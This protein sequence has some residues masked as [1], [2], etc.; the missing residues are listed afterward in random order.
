MT[1]KR[2]AYVVLGMHRSNTSLVAGC[3]H[4]AGVDF[5]R[6][7]IPANENNPTG[8]WELEALN[9]IHD[10]ILREH[11]LAW[12]SPG[13]LP[14]GWLESTVVTRARRDMIELLEGEFES[15]DIF[16]IK[17]PR[18]CRFVPLWR[19]IFE[20]KEIAVRWLFVVRHPDA[21]A[22]S[23][24]RRGDMP[25]ARA[26]SLWASYNVNV[27]A[28][29]S[30]EDDGFVLR[31]E[32]FV[33]DP[34]AFT[35]RALGGKWP[36]T[37]EGDRIEEKICSFCRPDLQHFKPK[38]KTAEF[39]DSPFVRLYNELS[40]EWG[41]VGES[42]RTLR[43]ALQSL[44]SEYREMVSERKRLASR[45][46]VFD[47]GRPPAI[48]RFYPM[49]AKGMF[50]EWDAR[51]AALAPLTWTE[52][53]FECDSSDLKGR[54]FFRIDPA[55]AC[56]EVRLRD[57]VWACAEGSVLPVS[58]DAMRTEGPNRVF[59]RFGGGVDLFL[60]GEEVHLLI[61]PPEGIPSGRVILRGRIRFEPRLPGIEGVFRDL[62][63]EKVRA[64]EEIARKQREC[65]VRMEE[66]RSLV[67]RVELPSEAAGIPMRGRREF[68]ASQ[69][70]NAWYQ[71]RI[72]GDA[73]RGFWAKY[74]SARKRER[75]KS[76]RTFVDA[77][78]FPLSSGDIRSLLEEM[79]SGGWLELAEYL[80]RYPD[81][82]ASGA[83]PI[84]HYFLHGWREGRWISRKFDPAFYLASNPDVRASRQEPL[85]HFFLH[86]KAEGRSPAPGL[87]VGDAFDPG[88]SSG[89]DRTCV[90]FFSGEPHTPGHVYRI[91]RLM[92]LLPA[93]EFETRQFKPGEEGLLTDLLERAEWLWIWRAPISESLQQVIDKARGLGVQ[94][95]YDLDDLMIRPELADPKVIDGIRSMRLKVEETVDLYSRTQ[96]AFL[97][98]DQ[99][100]APTA[101]LVAEMNRFYVPTIQI[102]NGF[103][104]EDLV[105]ARIA[106]A[107]RPRDGKIR[108]GYACGSRTHQRDFRIVLPGLCAV[109]RRHPETVFTTFPDAFLL[110][111][112]PELKEFEDRIDRR[113]M[114]PVTDL[115]CEYARFDVNLA[116]V[117]MGN[118]FCEAK[119]ELKF[120]EAVLV[121]TPTIASPV[122][123]FRE[124]IRP[125]DNGFLAENEREWEEHLEQLVTDGSLRERL[126]AT[127]AEES[128]W[129]F[130]PHRR[131]LLL[132]HALGNS[133]SSAKR[134]LDWAGHL[135][136]RRGRPKERPVSGDY[137]VVWRMENH[138]RS[139]VSV[140]IPVFNYARFLG[141]AL[142][143]VA[144]QSLEDLDLV[145]VDDASTDHS[146]EVAEAWLKQ[147]AERFGS[148]S[149][150]RH[151]ENRKLGVARNTGVRFSQTEFFFP[152]DP[153][154]W[155]K[156]GCLELCLGRLEESAASVVYPDLE[157]I[158]TDR[159]MI[160]GVDW[161]PLRFASGNYID[162]M[163]LIRKSVWSGL[164]GYIAEADLLG[165]EDFEFW[166]R[167]VGAGLY[168]VRLPM[169]LASYR[170]HDESM[171][172]KI[173]DQDHFKRKVLEK[174]EKLHPWLDL[175]RE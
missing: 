52:V 60:L 98:S 100:S 54:D 49:D 118:R 9:R 145:I 95:H 170:I 171:L 172:K 71:R 110:D 116:P 166:C 142:D 39:S 99:A 150:L 27:I 157:I 26:E 23:L 74:G 128:L 67:K 69:E 109:M 21:V 46:M 112:F 133:E 59:D 61:P 87:S 24:K 96:K 31:A 115:I 57:F 84:E 86:G 141:E 8:F 44:G 66:I 113:P 139:R 114:V 104:S 131:A 159:F 62:D 143:S 4:Q 107:C 75:R 7:L 12:D 38:D 174:M 137:E 126:A 147:H 90:C 13:M 43:V 51:Y 73:L 92:D 125:G 17:D 140:V 167:M 160:S 72:A 65:D 111:E 93:S 169:K 41:S 153:D 1:S 146:V 80:R 132:R 82:A 103:S 124:A 77:V 76:V 14:E 20:E 88:E 64:N 35:L 22:S 19:R 138:L 89:C 94:V 10:R 30:P 163:A 165:W 37:G 78:G 164:G 144:R 127:A 28:D 85:F 136:L 5:G 40:R 158:G 50:T 32:D 15:S 101:S 102:P 175:S 155:L 97:M 81:V 42:T 122:R 120:F 6:H 149:L 173:T 154:N 119:S 47:R 106:Q 36:D 148:A 58:F 135:L 55:N 129:T 123:P 91:N 11:G 105:S 83:N 70:R 134:A 25:T 56:G 168:G 161:H 48:A 53:E 45:A 79:V 130:G 3:L 117:E 156:S 68:T 121:G 63:E 34:A 18:L 2:K 33:D 162:A 16:G 108:I 152:L 29:L 151:N